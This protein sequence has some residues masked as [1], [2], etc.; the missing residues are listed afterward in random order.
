MKN[1]AKIST[2]KEEKKGKRFDS[3]DKNLKSDVTIV[4]GGLAGVMSAYLLSKKGKKVVLVEKKTIADG[5]THLTTA[6]LTHS[7]DTDYEDL[8]KNFGHKKS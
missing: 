6:F 5:A 8:I 1:P 7:I 3:L 2:W 4:G